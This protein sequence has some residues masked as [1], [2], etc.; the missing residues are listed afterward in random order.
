LLQRPEP[1]LPRRPDL[2]E[3]AEYI[4]RRRAAVAADGNRD[5][6]TAYVIALDFVC[7]ARLD[8]PIA[9]DHTMCR[10][11]ECRKAIYCSD[12]PAEEVQAAWLVEYQAELA[13]L[14]KVAEAA[15]AL[16]DELQRDE[17]T[18]EEQEELVRVVT[19]YRAALSSSV[20]PKEVK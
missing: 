3:V 7:N 18:D 19:A 14:R 11:C 2:D 9:R 17:R 16:V 1:A 5:A 6:E 12:C 4:E 13:A 10:S 15:E 8:V 20:L